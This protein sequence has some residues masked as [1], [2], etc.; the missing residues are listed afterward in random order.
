MVSAAGMPT[1]SASPSIVAST[2]TT[3]NVPFGTPMVDTS[4]LSQG[5]G[6][7]PGAALSKGAQRYTPY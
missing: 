1:V 2:A 4:Y 5:I 6:P 7:I 3:S